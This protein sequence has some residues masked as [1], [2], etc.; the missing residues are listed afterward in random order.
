M[1]RL[2]GQHLSGGQKDLLGCAIEA[3][4]AG[5]IGRCGR[6]FDCEVPSFF[7]NDSEGAITATGKG[8]APRGRP[9][10]SGVYVIAIG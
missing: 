10:D 4:R 5:A 9:F 3:H 6:L 1:A 2:G 8:L 7:S